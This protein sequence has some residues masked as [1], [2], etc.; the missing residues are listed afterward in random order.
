ML[1]GLF[2]GSLL[3]FGW[4][5]VLILIAGGCG[6]DSF[7]LTPFEWRSTPFVVMDCVVNVLKRHA[8]LAARSPL[9]VGECD[10]TLVLFH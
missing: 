8:L 9:C 10:E 1:H 3:G 6:R 2:V 4:V 5:L 7:N